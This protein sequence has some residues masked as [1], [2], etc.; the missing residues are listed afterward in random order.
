MEVEEALPGALV[1][2]DARVVGVDLDGTDQ[3]AES[4]MNVLDNLG[5]LRGLNSV[6]SS[7]EFG[8]FEN[9]KGRL[10]VEVFAPVE[11]EI[12]RHGGPQLFLSIFVEG[13]I[14]WHILATEVR[15]PGGDLVT[16]PEEN[17]GAADVD[18]ITEP[19]N[20]QMC[21]FA[22]DFGPV[23][24]FEVGEDHFFVIF[25]QFDMESA[26]SVV[27]ELN[28]ISFFAADGNRGGNIFEHTAPVGAINNT[29]SNTGHGRTKP[30]ES[31]GNRGLQREN[32]SYTRR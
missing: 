29:E 13:V 17:E 23:G 21:L 31:R 7:G 18:H 19:Q 15:Q 11:F 20:A 5:E 8:G 12:E 6:E 22:V 30:I 4:K 10:E 27:V 25:L 1:E 16:G 28:R 32:L 3:C 24:T 14:E 26:D 2:C 9:M